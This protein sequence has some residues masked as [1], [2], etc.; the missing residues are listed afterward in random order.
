MTVRSRNRRRVGLWHSLHAALWL[1]GLGILLTTGNLWPGILLLA[2][3]S[4]FLEGILIRLAP[5]TPGVPQENL[6]ASASAAPAPALP[7]AEH[8]LELLPA[9]CPQCGAPVRGDEVKWTGPQ[10]ADCT[11]CGAN[12]PLQRG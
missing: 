6:P 5:A 8:R 11:Y 4:L 7:A 3:L 1:I 10:S 9:A 2:A 12:L